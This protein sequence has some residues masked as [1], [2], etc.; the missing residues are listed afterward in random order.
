MNSGLGRSDDVPGDASQPGG[1]DPECR[2]TQVPT[3]DKSP[4]EL[5]ITL[6][7]MDL[8]DAFRID[9]PSSMSRLTVGDLLDEVFSE[10]ESAQN[11]F[12]CALD[13]RANPDLPEMYEELLEI[14]AEWRRGDCTLRFF[15]HDG[16]E[17]QLVDRVAE[18]MSIPRTGNGKVAGDPILDVV[19]EQTYDVLGR[20]AEWGAAQG[21][22]MKWLQR[23]T[24]LYYMDKHGF[25]LPVDP[26]DELSLGLLPIARDLVSSDLIAESEESGAFEFTEIGEELIEQMIAEA[27]SYIDRFDLFSDVL[28]EPDAQEVRFGTGYGVD[29]RV[30]VYWSEGV[31]P[32]RAL[33]LLLLYDSTLDAYAETW[34]EEMLKDE[35][36]N[37][38]LRPV[39]EHARVDDNLIGLVIES[40]YAHSEEISEQAIERAFEHDVSRRIR[41]E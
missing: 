30:Q 38:L 31:D 27:E 15:A 16:P 5:L 4:F 17:L 12:L 26:A 33:Y 35:F 11:R 34:R 25:R 8:E 1:V 37:G 36:F 13:V 7:D 22:L 10:D 14:L 32:L 21:G 9:L 39:L 24:L 28:L 3:L 29:L 41:S 23:H 6:G 40:G 2:R 18:H 19:I 20:F